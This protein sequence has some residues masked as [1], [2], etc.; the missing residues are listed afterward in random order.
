MVSIK[1]NIAQSPLYNGHSAYKCV[2]SVK[3]IIYDKR[4]LLLNYGGL[5]FS[6]VSVRDYPY[7]DALFTMILI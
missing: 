7:L 3:M 1:K 6:G 4:R 5:L 2:L